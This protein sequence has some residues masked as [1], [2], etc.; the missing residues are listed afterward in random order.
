[1]T[2]TKLKEK[3]QDSVQF[4]NREKRSGIMLPDYVSSI[5]AKFW[6]DQ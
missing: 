2:K 3:Y 4:V 5:L 1:M 6:Y